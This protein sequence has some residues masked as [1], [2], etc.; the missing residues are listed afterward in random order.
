MLVKSEFAQVGSVRAFVARPVDRDARRWPAVIAWS[1]I[2]QLTSPHL[3]LMTRLASRG[4]LVVAPELYGRLVAPGTVFGFDADRQAALD[5]SAATKL[6]WIDEDIATVLAAVEAR[7]DAGP[8]GV[9][10]WCFGG[11]V[12]LRAALDPRIRAAACCY[13]TGVHDGKLGDRDG[14]SARAETLSRVSR[15]RG[16]LLLVWGREDPHIPAAGRATIHAALEAAGTKFEAR[17]FDAQHTFM[18]DDLPP[19]GARYDGEATDAAFEAMVALYR[20]ALT[21]A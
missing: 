19:D 17:L 5:A 9:A 6:E 8:I 2:F 20:R 3:R 15:L 7:P 12:A 4:F 21:R 14:K 18:R 10:G 11:H 16:E 13:P 1:D